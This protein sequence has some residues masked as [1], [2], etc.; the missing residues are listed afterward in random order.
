MRLGGRYD[1]TRRVSC[2]METERG[3]SEI[4]HICLSSLQAGRISSPKWK[5]Q[6]VRWTTNLAML[7]RTCEDQ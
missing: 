2:L 7:T 3:Y 5:V 1:A 6:I 4:R